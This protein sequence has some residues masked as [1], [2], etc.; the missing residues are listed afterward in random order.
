MIGTG[1]PT[2]TVAYVSIATTVGLSLIVSNSSVTSSLTIESKD[3]VALWL[4]EYSQSVRPDEDADIHVD[5]P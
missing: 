4:E 5:W 1:S 3:H 2:D